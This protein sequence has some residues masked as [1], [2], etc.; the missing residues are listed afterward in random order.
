MKIEIK[1]KLNIT[2]PPE[3]IL[4]TGELISAIAQLIAALH[5]AGII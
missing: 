1:D 3:S 4:A 5:L 2:I